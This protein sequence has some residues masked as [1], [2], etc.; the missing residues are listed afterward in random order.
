MSPASAK[1]SRGAL[2]SLWPRARGWPHSGA[3][4]GGRG[5]PHSGAPTG[6]RG[7]AGAGP[8]REAAGQAWVWPVRRNLSWPQASRGARA[9]QKSSLKEESNEAK[10]FP[11][12]REVRGWEGEHGLRMEAVTTVFPQ[13]PLL[14]ELS[15]S[16]FPLPWKAVDI[17]TSQG[18]S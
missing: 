11:S 7:A 12:L 4:T 15:P 14:S 16:S 8:S 10:P 18:P 3:P 17:T 6:G 2:P 9:H 1:Q 13:L 5:W